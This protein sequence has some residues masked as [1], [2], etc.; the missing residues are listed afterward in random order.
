MQRF[1]ENAFIALLIRFLKYTWKLGLWGVFYSIRKRF[2]ILSNACE[3]VNRKTRGFVPRVSRV[4]RAF[5]HDIFEHAYLLRR[6]S[7]ALWLYSSL[8]LL[9]IQAN[10]FFQGVFAF[11]LLR[12]SVALHLVWGWLAILNW[13]SFSKMKDKDKT[14]A[15]LN[16][17]KTAMARI[18][19]LI[20]NKVLTLV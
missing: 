7:E 19:P 13:G 10:H 6:S 11:T 15:S 2:F 20:D 12:K 3:L 18:C 16:Q 4:S 1:T 14:G 17:V 9:V 8:P 5:T